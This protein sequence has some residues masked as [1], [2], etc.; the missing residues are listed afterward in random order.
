MK[1]GFTPPPILG[2]HLNIRTSLGRTIH[3]PGQTD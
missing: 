1:M 2:L 3:V